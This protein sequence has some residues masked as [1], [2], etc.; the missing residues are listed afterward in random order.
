[1]SL[2]RQSKIDYFNTVSE[3]NDLVAL[4]N[5]CKP[6]VCNK[7]AVGDSKTIH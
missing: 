5:Y 3:P 7:Y 2:N 4:W 6:Y 1:M